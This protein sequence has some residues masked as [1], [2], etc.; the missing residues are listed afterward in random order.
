MTTHTHRPM[1]P[2]H[3]FVDAT[4]CADCGE[5]IDLRV[6]LDTI[7]TQTR[8]S[9][10]EHERAEGLKGEVAQLERALEVARSGR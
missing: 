2:P 3:G 7:A 5:L 8:I 4:P 1:W 9:K 10:E 6:C